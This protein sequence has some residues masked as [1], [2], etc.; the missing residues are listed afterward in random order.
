MTAAP[1]IQPREQSAAAPSPF[2]PIAQAFSHL[3]LME[4]AARIIVPEPIEQWSRE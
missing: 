1:S 3:A 4:A 2:P